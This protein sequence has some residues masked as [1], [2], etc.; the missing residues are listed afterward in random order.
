MSRD[1]ILLAD[2]A[3][4]AIIDL[5]LSYQLRLGER[6][7]VAQLAERLSLGRTPVKEAIARLQAEGLLSVAGR[8][9][10][11][12]REIDVTTAR[13]LFALRRNLEGF[14]VEDAV[15]FVT[16]KDLQDLRLLL[17]QLQWSPDP[18]SNLYQMA[19]RYVRSNVRFHATIVRCARNATLDR[20]YGQV[21]MQAQIVIYLYHLGSDH[22]AMDKKY[23]EHA[24]I[25]A[26]LEQRDAATLR[27]LLESHAVATEESVVKSLDALPQSR[28]RDRG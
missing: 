18:S 8:S 3:Y 27:Q 24:A 9:G 28:Q 13:Q 19:A 23:Q 25:L 5:I 11:T 22:G 20:L 10:T 16:E 21:Q 26:A 15:R 6:T 2:Q 4:D 14:A 12:V 7:S 1:Q 17:A